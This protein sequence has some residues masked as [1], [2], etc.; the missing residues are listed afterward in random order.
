MQ[1]PLE[2]AQIATG[3][4]R[5]RAKAAM[6]KARLVAFLEIAGLGRLRAVLPRRFDQLAQQFGADGAGV[7]LQPSGGH[8]K[9]FRCDDPVFVEIRDGGGLAHIFDR[10]CVDVDLSCCGFA[11]G[12]GDGVARVFGTIAR[13]IND[14]APTIGNAGKLADGKADCLTHRRIGPQKAARQGA[15]A[16][17]KAAERLGREHALP[18]QHKGLMAEARPLYHSKRNLPLQQHFGN[19]GV[20]QGLIQP[21]DLQRVFAPV[22]RARNINGQQQRRFAGARWGGK[23]QGNSKGAE[24]GASVARPCCGGKG[25]FVGGWAADEVS[26]IN[27]K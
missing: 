11:A 6:A 9:A 27:V 21:I 24:H 2:P 4:V 25:F 19:L 23:H 18:W 26:N 14:M 3:A 13:D 22:D 12:M 1:R 5:P 10:D 8:D 20:A 7:I 17:G 15:G 16:L